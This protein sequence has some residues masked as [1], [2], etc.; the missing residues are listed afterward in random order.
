M[1]YNS[2]C[3]AYL[4]LDFNSNLRTENVYFKDWTFVDSG[5]SQTLRKKPFENMIGRREN[6][7]NHVFYRFKESTV[8]VIC[9]TFDLLTAI[10]FDFDM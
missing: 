6:A 8:F 7:G 9:S 2:I 4:F 5:V 10:T 1:N 3:L